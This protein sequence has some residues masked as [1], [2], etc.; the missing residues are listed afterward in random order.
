MGIYRVVNRV[1]GG[2]DRLKT[3][4]SGSFGTRDGEYVDLR[5]MEGISRYLQVVLLAV[6]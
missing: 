2:Y 1:N 5:R 4:M 6:R 3:K